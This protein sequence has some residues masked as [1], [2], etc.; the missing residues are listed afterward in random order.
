MKRALVTGGAGFIG[1]HIVEALL[2]LGSDVLVIDN[3]STGSERNIAAAK[4]RYGAKFEL[5]VL[6]IRTEE[7]AAAV[8]EFKPEVIFHLAAQIS[9]RRS[10]AE[11][12]YDSTVNVAGTVN[13]LEAARVAGTQKFI[14]A[15]TGGAIYGEQEYF[16][17]D[18]R[19]RTEPECPYG[20]S[21]RSAELFMEYFA[22]A[23]GIGAVALRFANVYGPRQNS[24]GEAGVVA[25][26]SEKLI[27]GQ[28]LNINGDGMQTRDFV[29]VHDVMRAN[30][31][32]AEKAVVGRFEMYNVGTGK[33]HTVVDLVKAMQRGW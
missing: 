27:A 28:P 17:A 20:V 24:K 14:F 32:A 13:M 26:F 33:E 15:S 4:A 22:R 1:S 30:L 8:V 29:H 10:V 6:D 18:E 2:D 16:P 19:H 9:V 12:M 25:I 23:N 11:P 31:L 21:K 5:R 3:L 7:A